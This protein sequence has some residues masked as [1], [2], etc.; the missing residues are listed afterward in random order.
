MIGD[1]LLVCRHRRSNVVCALVMEHEC[2]IAV[3]VVHPMCDRAER[4]DAEREQQHARGATKQIGR[5]SQQGPHSISVSRKAGGNAAVVD[6]R[7]PPQKGAA[8]VPQANRDETG[9][10]QSVRTMHS[11][12]VA[13]VFVTIAASVLCWA[14]AEAFRSR[15]L[16]T[17]A[18]LLMLTHSILAFGMFYGWSHDTAR[19]ATMQQTAALTGIDFA[20]GIYV[21]YVFLT[22]W[23][24]DVVWWWASRRSYEARPVATAFA[25]RGFIFFIIV[26]GAVVFADGWA[27]GVGIAA[28]GLV[29]CAWLLRHS[30]RRGASITAG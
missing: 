19:V 15:S 12:G 10:L 7:R 13:T 3:L 28:T 1:I 30:S 22:V 21:N 17:A 14:V 25:I 26:N 8:P 27:R 16:W 2:G 29:V 18:A 20:G 24:A 5:Q 11:A 4:R 9:R 6:R 23:L